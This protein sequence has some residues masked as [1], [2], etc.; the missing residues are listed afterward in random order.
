MADRI[1]TCLFFLLITIPAAAEQSIHIGVSLG[2]TGKYAVMGTMQKKGYGLWVGDV[3]AKGGI[4]GKTVRMSIHDDQSDPGKAKD[5]YRKMI[6]KDRVDLVFGPYSSGVTEA[7]LPVV[8]KH[9]YPV[10]MS[11]AS[12]DR[13]WEKGY[14]YAFG[15]YT[16]ASKYAVGFL[17]MLVKNKVRTTAIISA[18]DAF[19]VS[20]SDNTRR[21]A[22]RFHLEVLLF[23]R[24]E[25]GR[26][27]LT[28]IVGKVRDSGAQALI[29][30][31]HLAESVTVAKSLKKTGFYPRAYYASVGPATK[32]FRDI[33]G[34]DAEFAFSSS[35][36]EE[37]V[38]RHFPQGQEFV[39]AFNDLYKEGP[40]Y[41]AATAYASGMIL[42]AA[43]NKIG[44]V[45]RK[46]LRDTLAV[47]DTMTVIGRYGVDKSG[48]QMRHFPLIVQ[49]QAGEKKV[50]WPEK[51]REAE[52]IFK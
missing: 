36:W 45:D 15:V 28:G 11:G 47:M 19:S 40:S 1:L 8:E 2:M 12:A 29:V 37:K 46:R 6:E 18:D 41:H 50:V 5:I 22:K 24:F 43:L 42:E 30:C 44:S 33:L 9:R 49:W 3:N 35:Q 16:P 39:D 34:N 20:L 26:E 21:W 17:Q 51:L 10:L 7:I 14:K 25:K 38:G 13:L 23:E 27:D 4:L 31:G 48:R 32:E 52:P